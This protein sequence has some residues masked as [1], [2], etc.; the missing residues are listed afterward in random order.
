M[1]PSS[2]QLV[3]MVVFAAILTPPSLLLIP[4]ARQ[5]ASFDRLLAISTFLIAFLG[6]WL[7]AS[8][9]VPETPSLEIGGVTVLPILAGGL[10]AVVILNLVLWLLD[11]LDQP[12]V[13]P[14]D[15]QDLDLD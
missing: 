9:W 2:T 1:I 13:P 7:V 12:E 4:H 6:E 15:E 5:S 11:R 14:E 10:G 8:Q 3:I